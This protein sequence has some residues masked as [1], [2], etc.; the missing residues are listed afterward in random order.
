MGLID[1]IAHHGYAMTA[2]V[3][4]LAAVGLPLPMSIALLAAGAAS[5]HGLQMAIVFP[6]AWFAAV[7]G[8]TLLYFGG[9]YTGWWL[10]SGMCRMSINPEQ[11]IFSSAGYFYR[12]GQKTL[13]FAKFI[14]GLGAMAAPLAG[15]L[16]MRVVRFLR[17]DALGV[18]IYCSS[19]LLTG[20]VFS[21]FIREIA[22]WI[23]QAS[24]AV[25]YLVLL[26]GVGYVLALIIFT[27]RAQRYKEVD[28]ISAD[29]LYER[30]QSITPDRLVIIAD[31]RSHGYYDPGM[32]RIKNSIRVEPNRLK[33][34][35]IAL[36]EFMVP[37]CDVYLYCS[38]LRD[39]TSVR[40][41]HM[42][43]KEN[44]ST[45]VITGG[46]KAWIK[47]GGDVEMV[48]ATDIQHLPTFD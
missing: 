17:L 45:H 38:C 3:M 28:R 48:P 26:L 4:F 27:T 6:V 43:K 35:L 7:A 18:L 8:D 32:Q 10:L 21:R 46:M 24:H 30:M 39:T 37:E 5:K 15:T 40:V 41:A 14:P 16:N 20:Y 33:E 13:L 12:R 36:R 42:L 9:R 22:G 23:T 2:V 29:S 11:C 19:W 47:A 1:V 34:E 25:L 44:C 31:V